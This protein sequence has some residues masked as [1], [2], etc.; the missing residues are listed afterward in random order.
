MT[1][2]IAYAL[3]LSA[4]VTLAACSDAEPEPTEGILD[5]GTTPAMTEDAV[6]TPVA[7]ELNP[8]QQAARDKVD[9]AALEKETSQYMKEDQ[10]RMAA[11]G[12]SGSGNAMSGGSMNNSSDKM[13]GGSSNSGSNMSGSSNSGSNM[14]G[15]NMG[16]YN[17]SSNFSDLDR[18]ND[19]KLSVAEYAVWAVG[20]DPRSKKA[21][22]NDQ[23]RPYVDAD[24]LN[25]AADGFYYYDQNGD[26]YLQENE[27]QSAKAGSVGSAAAPNG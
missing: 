19:G 23:N 21:S 16:S 13:A 18:N 20:A 11:S 17:A 15:S 8:T 22:A 4:A 27:F 24:A 9:M 3:S 5:D 2:T 26:T 25:S 10:D 12:N 6:V 14:S 7:V 1:R